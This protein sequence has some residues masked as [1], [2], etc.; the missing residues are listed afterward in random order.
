MTR[1]FR[2]GRTE[3]VRSCSIESSQWVKAMEDPTKSKTERI[4][5]LR[6]ASDYHQLQ[7]RDAMSGKGIDRHLFCLY[8]LSKYFN[9][10]SPFL[11][12][13]LHEPWKLSTS[14]TP[15]TYD[16]KRLPGLIAK[17]LELATK[18]NV[19]GQQNLASGGGGFGPVA[20]D[21]YGVSY[22]IATEDLIFFHISSNKSSPETDSKRFGQRIRQAM[23]DMRSLFE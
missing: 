11:Q 16:D 22:I 1:L 4:K 23:I 5:L 15:T 19:I 12:Q 17:N 18:Y 7:Y 13:V 2:D 20:T 10:D 9:M 14:Q 8:V 6:Q 21:G 3:T